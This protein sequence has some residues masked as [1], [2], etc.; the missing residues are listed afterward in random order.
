VIGC[1]Y[2]PRAGTKEGLAW[3]SALAV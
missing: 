2:L 1:E 3:R